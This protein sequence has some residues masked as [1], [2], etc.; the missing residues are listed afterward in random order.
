MTKHNR[1]PCSE[2]NT[3]VDRIAKA[4][5]AEDQQ[6][7]RRKKREAKKRDAQAS[8]ICARALAESG[9]VIN[10]MDTPK[11]QRVAVDALV[12]GR[13]LDGVRQ[14]VDE[15]ISVNRRNPVHRCACG[16]SLENETVLDECDACFEKALPPC[17]ASM[18]CL[19]AGHARGNPASARCDTSETVTPTR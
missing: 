14:A 15:W 11:I 7:E 6:A 2:G 3:F 4:T 5:K 9:A 18:G 17:A 19:C 12:S 8:A 13:T 1:F 10:I 16:A